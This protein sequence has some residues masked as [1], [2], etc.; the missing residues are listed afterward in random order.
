M[1]FFVPTLFSNRTIISKDQR[2]TP[3]YSNIFQ[4]IIQDYDLTFRY[5]PVGGNASLTVTYTLLQ[6]E[7]EKLNADEWHFITVAVIDN[8][9][10]YYIDGELLTVS[11]VTL[12]G[13]LQDSI[14]VIMIG[15][16]DAGKKI[17]KS[18]GFN[19][20]YMYTVHCIQVSVKSH[21]LAD[22]SLQAYNLAL[23]NY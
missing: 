16:N 14:G 6:S 12:S 1:I 17:A 4:L 22:I 13:P 15:R 8:S 9:L 2:S 20:S 21:P 7:S 11:S 5:M 10:S 18:M 23:T 3:P 19:L